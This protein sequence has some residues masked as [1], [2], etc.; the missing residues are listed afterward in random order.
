MGTEFDPRS[1]RLVDSRASCL[2]CVFNFCYQPG[3]MEM[4]KAAEYYYGAA[5][6]ALM[7]WKKVPSTPPSKEVERLRRM[8]EII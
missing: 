1:V 2:G 5:C 7:A 3:K 4:R 6:G 8:V